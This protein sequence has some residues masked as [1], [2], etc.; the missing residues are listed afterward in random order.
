MVTQ[1]ELCEFL[2]ESGFKISTRGDMPGKSTHGA[3]SDDRGVHFRWWPDTV[4]SPS[5]FKLVGIK[6]QI[7]LLTHCITIQA[8]IRTAAGNNYTKT[9]E[10]FRLTSL[11]QLD[12]QG[13]PVARKKIDKS[14]LPEPFTFKKTGCTCDT[15]GWYVRN[16]TF[17]KVR[18]VGPVGLTDN[19]KISDD[20]AGVPDEEVWWHFDCAAPSTATFNIITDGEV[21]YPVNRRSMRI[22]TQLKPKK[23][24]DLSY[25][26]T[27]DQKFL[28][29]IIEDFVGK[30]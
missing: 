15:K 21:W 27:D 30:I 19:A 20:M 13:A 1:S 23:S 7:D 25:L 6:P 26:S 4:T 24:V 22:T 12:F 3:I 17:G 28:V 5:W 9:G 11:E 10:C 29:R 18:L 16:T 8:Y 14:K 2:V